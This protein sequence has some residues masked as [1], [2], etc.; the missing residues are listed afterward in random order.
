VTIK[1]SP[2]ASGIGGAMASGPADFLILSSC[3]D[4]VAKEEKTRVNITIIRNIVYARFMD[5]I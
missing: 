1:L 5:L 2:P 3:A 4:N